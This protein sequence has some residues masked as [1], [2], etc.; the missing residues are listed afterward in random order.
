[1]KIVLKEEE[2]RG[3]SS[4][5]T[6]RLVKEMSQ[7]PERQKEGTFEENSRPFTRLLPRRRSFIRDRAACP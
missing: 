2:P 1:M 7:A 3:L 4:S 6:E 5:E